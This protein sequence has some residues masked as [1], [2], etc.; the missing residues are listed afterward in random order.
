MLKRN[1]HSMFTAAPFT[2]AKKWKQPKHPSM[3]KWIKT[4][5]HMHTVEYYSVSQKED[6]LFATA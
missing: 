4:M 6:L 2:S 1:P 3:D 5:W